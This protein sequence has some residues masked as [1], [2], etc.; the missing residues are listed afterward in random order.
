MKICTK[1]QRIL[2]ESEFY[3]RKYGLRLECKD[4]MRKQH[5][6][7]YTNHK[8]ERLEKT[9][10][11]RLKNKKKMA[12]YI[13][14]YRQDHKEEIKSKMREYYHRH[15]EKQRIYNQDH[16]EERRVKQRRYD[17]EHKEE[18]KDKY[19]ERSQT[20]KC[21]III[22]RKNAKR[23]RSLGFIPF[24]IFGDAFSNMKNI[25]HHCNDAIVVRMPEKIHL[26]NYGVD[27][28]EKIADYFN[29]SLNVNIF[30]ELLS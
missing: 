2:S 10:E 21:K 8:E 4:C 5:L 24:N 20:E 12:D 14:K 29:N 16:K 9:K 25:G 23:N 28:R 3:K 30:Q 1:C 11:Y 15:K 7:Y 17:Q 13:K 26:N 22:A 18:K 27:H 19:R 6:E